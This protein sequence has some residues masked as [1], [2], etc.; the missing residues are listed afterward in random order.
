ML[1]F[2]RRIRKGLLGTGATGKYLLY[3]IGE[4]AL[5]VIGILIALQINNWHENNKREIKEIRYLGD[6]LQDLNQDSLNL[7]RMIKSFEI[8]SI[9]KKWLEVQFHIEG[10][11]SESS[12]FHLENQW[13]LNF[14]FIP[15]MT[16]IEELKSSSNMDL[17][18]NN[19][20]RRK[21]VYLYNQY[22]DLRQKLDLGKVKREEI[23]D[24]IS[25]NVMD[26][27]NPTKQEINH[28]FNDLYFINKI[29][30]NYLNTLQIAITSASE[31]CNQ[32]LD[33][34]RNE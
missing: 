15:Q 8:A 12:A 5:V 33:L 31:N 13:E 16:T 27:E 1:T 3:A 32:A 11:P 23:I 21:L 26:V 10:Q 18:S 20:L 29:R 4:I 14:D 7:S 25:Q 30:M 22:D 24:I 6:L 2:F 28:L 17:I 34:L 9:S 19:S